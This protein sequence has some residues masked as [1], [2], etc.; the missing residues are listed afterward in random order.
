[1]FCNMFC[2]TPCNMQSDVRAVSERPTVVLRMCPAGMLCCCTTAVGT[3]NAISSCRGSFV[4]T[5]DLPTPAVYGP[6][7]LHC[8]WLQIQLASI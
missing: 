6:S 8:V 7:L 2:N 3:A 1:M 5:D 4:N